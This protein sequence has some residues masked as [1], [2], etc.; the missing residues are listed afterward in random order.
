MLIAETV[1]R[2]R[3][4]SSQE[5]CEAD[6][7]PLISSKRQR[8]DDGSRQ[9]RRAARDRFLNTLSKVWLTPKALWEFDRRNA[10]QVLS[11]GAPQTWSFGLVRDRSLKY[12]IYLQRL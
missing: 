7:S 4:R 11:R 8:A 3:K 5:A 12:H 6:N 1:P 9:A 2:K 10:A